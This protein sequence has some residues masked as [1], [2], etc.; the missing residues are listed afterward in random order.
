METD[1][2]KAAI[3]A[4]LF[5]MSDTGE[6]LSIAY[7]SRTLSGNKGKICSATE[8]EPC[9][10][11]EATPKWKTYCTNKVIIYTDH[12]PLQ[13]AQNMKDSRGKI[14]RLVM[15]LNELDYEIR[16]I[17]GND[18]C[19]ADALSPKNIPDVYN[20]EAKVFSLEEY[21][22]RKTIRMY[23]KGDKILKKVFQCIKN[24]KLPKN[25]PFKNVQ[26]S[27]IEEG[28]LMKFEIII[29]PVVRDR[30]YIL[31]TKKFLLI[32]QLHCAPLVPQIYQKNIAKRSDSDR[33][34]IFFGK[35]GEME[36]MVF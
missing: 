7:H 16:Y 10:I 14:A 24:G 19:A 27:N 33:L 15:E 28:L 11:L 30:V 35:S 34:A 5:Q 13:Y 17:K 8:K 4:I 6:K 1:I 20:E 18:N 2:S 3:G 32:L 26:G 29:V 21:P 23:Q 9:A 31:V 25:G 36:N 22:K 12:K